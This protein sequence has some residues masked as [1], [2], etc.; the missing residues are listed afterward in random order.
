MPETRSRPARS[1]CRR[2]A[3]CRGGSSCRRRARRPRRS[4]AASP[5]AKCRG[6]IHAR[7]SRGSCTRSVMVFFWTPVSATPGIVDR[8]R[9]RCGLDVAEPLLDLLPRLRRVDVAGDDE[10]GVRGRVVLLEERYDVVVARRGQVLHVADH[11][12]VVGMTLRDTASRQALS[13]AMPYG[14]FSTL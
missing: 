3:A 5:G 4:R 12:P 9:R 10:A 8:L 14:R 6:V 2:R 7:Y 13:S 11:R 1:A